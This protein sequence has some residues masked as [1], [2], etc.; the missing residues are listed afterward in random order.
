MSAK[1]H[2]FRKADLLSIF[3]NVAYLPGLFSFLRE[4]PLTELS[5]NQKDR[6]SPLQL[7]QSG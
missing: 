5:L 4:K 6:H 1:Q 7:I 2:R 3:T